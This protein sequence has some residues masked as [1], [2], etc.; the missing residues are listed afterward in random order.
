VIALTVHS[1]EEAR[2][3][4]FQAG[5]DVFIVKGAPVETLVRAIFKQKE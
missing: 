2:R 3:K 4:A 1:Y 5:V